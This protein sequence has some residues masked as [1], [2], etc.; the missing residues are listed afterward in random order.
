MASILCSNCSTGIHYHSE[1]QGIEY[2]FFE[3]EK[4]KEICNSR[5]NPQFKE[6]S[7]DG[8]PKLYK[9][10]TIE[11]DFKGEFIKLW[12]CPKCKSLM[13]FGDNGKVVTCFIPKEKVLLGNL[14]LE[15]LAFADDLWERITEKARPDMELKGQQPSV[16]VRIYDNG[17]EISEDESFD[18]LTTYAEL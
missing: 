8:Y 9:T 2:M 11:E 1:P 13:L 15:G 6:I 10:D 17:L 4:W 14:K 18:S 3:V 5:F 12:R 16:Y 7:N